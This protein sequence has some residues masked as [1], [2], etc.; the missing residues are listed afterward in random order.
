M[1]ATSRNT[2]FQPEDLKIYNKFLL[3]LMIGVGVT[4]LRLLALYHNNI[5]LWVDEAQY[6]GWSKNIAAGYYSK[7]PFIAWAIGF[8]TSLF[9][10]ET[11]GIRFSAPFT[12]PHLLPFIF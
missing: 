5:P 4:F 1:K 9:G 11:F 2:I 3:L 12:L 8:T 7:P 6:W 10:D